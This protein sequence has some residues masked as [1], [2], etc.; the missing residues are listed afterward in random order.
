[1]F[2]KPLISFL[3]SS[4]LLCAENG[5]SSP[6]R[7]ENVKSPAQIREEIE[8]AQREFEIAQKM[9]IPWYTGPLITGSA[10]NVPKGKYNVQGYLYTTVNYAQ[11]NS[12]RKSITTPKTTILNPLLV[13]Q[14]G[15][16]DWLDLSAFPQ[17]FFKWRQDFYAGNFGD[18]GAQFGFQ[19]VKE[20]QYI[21]SIRFVLGEV[22]PTGKYQ[23]L[24]SEKGGLDSTGSGAFITV[25]GL[26]VSKTLW[27]LS[28]HPIAIRLATNYNVPDH[29][30]HVRGFNAYGGGFGTD[31]HVHVGNTFN[32]D[33]GLEVSLTQKWVFATDLAYTYSNKSTFNGYPGKTSL[34]EPA[35]NGGP[36]SDQLSV[37]PAIEYNVSDTA[38]FIGGVWFSVT[39]RNSANFVSLVLSYTQLF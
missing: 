14:A 20:K 7:A 8:Q 15:L 27:W 37:A 26:N 19:I 22:F 25:V 23:R 29:H 3:L 31:G 32:A 18:L 10:N 6:L 34:C 30:V 1:M 4:A 13:L 24:S 5:D 11:F 36:S 17:G 12:R 16:T 39:G 38:G 21:P 2:K 33:L 9:F 28:L 35:A